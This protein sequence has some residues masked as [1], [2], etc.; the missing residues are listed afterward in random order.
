MEEMKKNS[1][2]NPIENISFTEAIVTSAL[3]D[4]LKH[5]MVDNLNYYLSK[6]SSMKNVVFKSIELIKDKDEICFELS[7]K[8]KKMIA[9]GKACFA[10]EKQTGKVLPIIKDAKTGRYIEQIKGVKKIAGKIS[11]LSALIVSSAHVISGAD[12]SKKLLDISKKI[13]FLLAV[14]KIDQFARLEATYGFIRELMSEPL[15]PDVKIE[16]QREIKEV[17]RLRSE[18]RQ[19]LEYG[20]LNIDNPDNRNWITK[21]FSRVK[22]TDLNISKSI[23][24][25]Q[26]EIQL[27][28]FSIMLQ[29]IV[30][31]HIDTQNWFIG[32]ALPD[33]IN[34]LN[35]I[36]SLLKEKASY[37]SGR[38]TNEGL[39]ATPVIQSFSSIIESYDTM[40][41]HFTPTTEDDMKPLGIFLRYFK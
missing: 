35:S 23:I 40:I 26:A 39:T 9:S 25:G 2:N 21:F 37:I 11:K 4:S 41:P 18:W 13:D 10:I 15:T 33:E 30:S 6:S 3:P 7:S 38:Y 8:S 12:L 32:K 31:Y 36:L 27:I 34:S 5:S 16:L 24:Q 1:I 28:N 22:T 14:R 20:L 19:E 29:T 17:S